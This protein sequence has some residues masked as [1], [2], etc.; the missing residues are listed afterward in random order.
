MK[1]LE[2]LLRQMLSY[3]DY[4]KQC[5][6][7]S[8]KTGDIMSITYKTTKTFTAEE[9]QR[10]FLSVSWESGKY[11]EKLVRAMQNSTH[12]ISAWD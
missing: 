1:K 4:V 8:K 6:T 9:L 12:V 10:L 3:F 7:M 11:P 5:D 2:Y